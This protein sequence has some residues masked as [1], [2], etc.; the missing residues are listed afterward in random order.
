MVSDNSFYSKIYTEISLCHILQ[1]KHHE[2]QTNDMMV[3]TIAI[4]SQAFEDG[5][6]SGEN[7]DNVGSDL[8][9]SNTACNSDTDTSNNNVNE[10]STML[11]DN[12]NG[13]LSDYN[14]HALPITEEMP[15]PAVQT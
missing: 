2:S 14:G 1:D 3:M 12:N 9:N 8:S 11:N 6:D 7:T 4:N 10:T 13:L 5:A 15:L